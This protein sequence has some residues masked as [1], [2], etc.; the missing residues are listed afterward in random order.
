MGQF[1][2]TVVLDGSAEIDTHCMLTDGM[3]P[4][5]EF[6]VT[7]PA[8]LPA[9]LMLLW[10]TFKNTATYGEFT[11]YFGACIELRVTFSVPFFGEVEAVNSSDILEYVYQT[12]RRHIPQDFT[13]GIRR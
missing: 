7:D 11:A 13:L 3:F 4:R 6:W 10:M 9:C 8:C 12:E 2:F 5:H 1:L